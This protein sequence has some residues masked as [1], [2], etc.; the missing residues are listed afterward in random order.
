VRTPVSI[1]VVGLGYWGPNLARVFSELPQVELRWL[2]DASPEVQLAMRSRYPGVRTTPE[3]DDLLEDELLD[4]VA[5]AT[6]VATHFELARR[7]LEADKHVFVEKP[8]AVSAAEA[9]DLLRL[10][11]A[12]GRRIMVGHV[13]IFHPAVRRL[14]ELIDGG[15]LG[16]IYYLYG[17]RQNLGKVR[18]DENALWSL[19]AHDVAVILHLLADEPVE[20]SARGESYVQPGVADVVFCY[21]RFAT[22]ISAHMHLS[23]LDP[24]KMRR[25]TAVGSQRMAVF[26]DMELERKLTVY[27]KSAAPRTTDTFGEY[28]QV[29]FG[30]IISPR[31]SNEEPL[32]VECEA[33]VSAVRSSAD[34]PCGGREGVAVV[35]VLEAL[36]R[37]LDSGG[38]PV[39]VT[40][41]AAK[42]HIVP[43]KLKQG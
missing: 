42:P 26:D 39:P 10:A 15:Q 32:R 23:W 21:L 9:E 31:V 8:L 12:R 29:R 43:L 5:I 14:K 40:G 25:L 18:R 7:V 20:V 4:A 33:F 22:G 19:G 36:Q 3:L 24:H 35:R 41:E 16:D 13:L 17:N 37:S 6:P 30:D 34:V 28:V 1:G 2:C 11:E 27:E 38:R